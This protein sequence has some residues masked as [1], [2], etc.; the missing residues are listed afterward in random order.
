MPITNRSIL[1]RANAAVARGDNEGFL[2]HC[3]DDIVW[4]TVG[5]ESL[6]GKDAVR[7]WMVLGYAEP[8]LFTVTQWICDGDDVA[9]LGSIALAAED[10]TPTSHT[11]CDVWRFRDGQMTELRAFVV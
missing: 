4:T 5:G 9:V 1:E 3:T 8:P 10:S 7:R 11:Y 6:I 2:A